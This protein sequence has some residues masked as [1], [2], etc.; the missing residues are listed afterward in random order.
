[1]IVYCMVVRQVETLRTSCS[2]TLVV[3][4][5]HSSS[6]TPWCPGLGQLGFV[7]DK[8]VLGRFSPSTLV[9]TVNLHSTRFSILTITC[10]RYNRPEVADVPNGPSMDSPPPLCEFKMLFELYR[11]RLEVN[12]CHHVGYSLSDHTVEGYILLFAGAV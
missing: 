9:S 2:V 12:M 7:V 4:L 11:K 1:M 8:A 5:H 6:F 10:C 3:R